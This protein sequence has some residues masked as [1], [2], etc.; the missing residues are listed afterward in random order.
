VL[1][2]QAPPS[3]R[4]E[5]EFVL[6]VVLGWLGQDYSLEIMPGLTETL[7]AAE[8]DAD[9]GIA[10]PDILFGAGTDWLGADSLPRRPLPVVEHPTGSSRDPLPLLFAVDDARPWLTRR[11]AQRWRLGFDLFGAVFFLLSRYEEHVIATRD[12]RGRFPAHASVMHADGWLRWPVADMYVDVLAGLLTSLWPH[13]TVRRDPGGVTIGH[14]VDH[15]SSAKRWQGLAR[16]RVVAADAIRRRDPVL[17]ARRALS[18]APRGLLSRLDPYA[19]FGFLMDESERVGSRSTFFFLTQDTELPAGSVYSLDEPWARRLI[20]VIAARGHHIGLHGSY[21]SSVDATRLAQEWQRLERATADLPAGVRR[22]A[23]RQHY[24]MLEPSVT[25]R[26]QAEAGLGA[27]ESLAYADDVGYR[28]G[29][30]RAFPAFDLERGRPLP[31]IVRPLHVMDVTISEYL[32]M[33]V[34]E[35]IPMVA[36]MARRT[37]R[38]G[39]QF[40]VL[41]HNNTLETR[42]DRRSYRELLEVL[43]PSTSEP[44]G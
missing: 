30:A 4:T 5:R 28:A 23:V 13:R 17:A 22:E 32:R 42:Q 1:R 27:D 41:W 7:V 40:S 9:G 14:D 8:G 25:W 33:P 11:D 39:G 6:S 43:L 24:L 37:D 31:L 15:P 10:V 34:R 18:F 21:L 2:I 29:T 3:H 19:T 38:Y 16:W 20:D 12:E 44:S 36:S 26:S 35:A